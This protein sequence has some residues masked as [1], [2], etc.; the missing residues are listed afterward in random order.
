ML[1][2]AAALLA[3]AADDTVDDAVMI[4]TAADDTVDDALLRIGSSLH[5]VSIIILLLALRL[6][7]LH[8]ALAL[9]LLLLLEHTFKQP[10]PRGPW[11]RILTFSEARAVPSLA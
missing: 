2:L 10:V 9:R 7:L 5:H 8:H 6:L 11:L 3:A 4:A 1:R